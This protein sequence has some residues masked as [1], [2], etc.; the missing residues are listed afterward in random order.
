[1]NKILITWGVVSVA[2][3]LLTGCETSTQT[4]ALVGGTTGALGGALIGKSIGGRTTEGALLGGAI[5]ALSG[6]LVGK[7]IDEQTRARVQQGQPLTLEDVKVLSRAGVEDHLIISQINATRTVYI[8]N[9]AQ[10]IDLKDAGVS[11]R[12]IDHMINTRS[13][14]GSP[15]Y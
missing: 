10:I 1:M 9:S 13:M 11:Q 4:G 2:A 8:L 14:Y 7:H 5:G 12:V 6:A 15:R 3:A